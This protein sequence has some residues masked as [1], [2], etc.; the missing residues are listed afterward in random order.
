MSFQYSFKD[1]AEIRLAI[2]DA[3][4]SYTSL[5]IFTTDRLNKRLDSISSDKNVRNAAFELIQWAESEGILQELLL[6]LQSDT[7]NPKIKEVCSRLL[8]ETEKQDERTERA[9]PTASTPSQASRTYPAYYPTY[10]YFSANLYLLTIT[11]S[12]PIALIFTESQTELWVHGVIV[13]ASIFKGLFAWKFLIF[14]IAILFLSS[15]PTGKLWIFIAFSLILSLLY[16]AI[17]NWIRE[18]LRY[19]A[20]WFYLTLTLPGGVMSS[21]LLG[22][23]LVTKF[24]VLQP[25]QWIEST[26]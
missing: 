9:E 22:R 4:R 8:L 10:Y 6:N 21:F 20:N 11:A 15:S 25:I 2:E 12:L 1:R 19:S 17:M 26:F 7:N 23:W 5:N 14:N 16:T 18:E 3:Y 13:A 24:P